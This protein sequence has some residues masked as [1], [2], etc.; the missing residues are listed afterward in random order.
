MSQIAAASS[1]HRRSVLVLQAGPQ[2]PSIRLELEDAGYEALS[3]LARADGVQRIV[4]RMG[5]EIVVLEVEGS[6]A[7]PQLE[8]AQT[9]R[10]TASAALVW[11]CPQPKPELLSRLGRT[12]AH[13][14]V[15][16]PVSTVQLTA[17]LEMAVAQRR[18]EL[19][20][21]PD[22]PKDERARRALLRI[23][24]VLSEWSVGP[25]TAGAWQGHGHPVE[26]RHV[27]GL[28]ELSEREWDVLRLLLTSL[29]PA[30]IARELGISL[31]TVR[32]H[33]K[34]IYGKVDVH[35]QAE[36]IDLV[37]GRSPVTVR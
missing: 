23:G 36:L 28:D 26:Q 17:T 29:R 4:E 6:Q 19:A 14:I 1:P 25:W 12:G 24:E 27:D 7:E 32:N 3:V 33:L 35:S 10:S 34:S 37:K 30:Q 20:P 9:L 18:R 8:A 15:V 31:N 22:A 5:P 16:P 11:L 21:A 13:G 2:A